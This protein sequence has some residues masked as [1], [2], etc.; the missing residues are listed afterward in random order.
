MDFGTEHVHSVMVGGLKDKIEVCVKLHTDH[1]VITNPSGAGMESGEGS[2]RYKFNKEKMKETDDP[3]RAAPIIMCKAYVRGKLTFS[4]SPYGW[5]RMEHAIE[6]G[7]RVCKGGMA[8]CDLCAAAAVWAIHQCSELSGL[9]I[10]AFGTGG[11]AFIVLNRKTG[12][13][14]NDPSSWGSDCLVVDVWSYNQGISNTRVMTVSEYCDLY[15]GGLKP[16]RLM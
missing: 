5:L 13:V 12:S 7:G 16:R 14:E 6:L 10:E 15:S 2:P 9:Q 1:I 4:P 11:H 8:D 3:E